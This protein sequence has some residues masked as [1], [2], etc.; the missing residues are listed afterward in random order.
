[1][2]ITTTIPAT[3]ADLSEQYDM[4]FNPLKPDKEAQIM[5]GPP[6]PPDW[7][8]PRRGARRRVSPTAPVD[9][10]TENPFAHL[11]DGLEV[12]PCG[13]RHATEQFL[14]DVGAFA[15]ARSLGSASCSQDSCHSSG[16]SSTPSQF[17]EVQG[18][19]ELPA[20]QTD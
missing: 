17:H 9:V 6:P 8:V 7:E 10:R 13:R 4:F 2:D 18:L 5:G 12:G 14:E 19:P 20:P 1:M 15:G 3:W 16:P 11:D